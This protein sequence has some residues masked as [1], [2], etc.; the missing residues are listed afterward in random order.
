MQT[1]LVTG[2]AGYIGSHVCKSL[3]LAGFLPVCLDHLKHGKREAVRYGPLIEAD[4]SHAEAVKAAISQYQ[5]TAVLHFAGLIQV[6]ESVAKPDLYFEE[7]VSKTLAFFQA[8]KG[9][10]VKSLVFS[11]TAAVYGLPQQIPISESHPT[12]PINPYGETKLAIEKALKW[13]GASFGWSHAA[14]RY[15]NAAGADLEGEIGECHEPETHLIPLAIEARL[16]LRPPLNIF[17]NDYDTADG[18]ALRDY[19]HVVDLAEAHLLMLRQLIEG[20]SSATLNLG[21]GQGYSV[22]Q[23]VDA[24]SEHTGA[25]TPALWAPRRAGDPAV[26]VADASAAKAQL[27]WQPQ[28]S[29]LKT[30]VTSAYAWHQRKLNAD[31]LVSLAN[32]QNHAN[33]RNVS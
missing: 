14:L 21:T 18:T 9:T 22:K 10:S 6:G 2:G 5:I 20:G 11:S 16:G 23:V 3:K 13:Y 31:G 24:V 12:A 19:I 8:L 4:I 30:I 7:N 27:A 15:F 25:K 28:Y 33:L 1:V 29:D 17:G 32:Q 26:L